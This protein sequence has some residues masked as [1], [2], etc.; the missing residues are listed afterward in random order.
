MNPEDQLVKERLR[1][2][3]EIQEAGK[4]PYSY[5]YDQKHKAADLQE[6]FKKLKKEAKAKTSVSVAGRL[7]ILRRMGKVTFA[8][9]QDGT[10][11]IQLYFKQDDIGNKN[12]KFLKKL[13]I[14]DI[15][16]VKGIIFRTKMGELTVYVKKYDL[17][18]KSLRPLPEKYHGLKDVEARYRQRYLDLIMNPDVKQTFITR[19]KIYNAMREF[20]TKE[21]F[22]EVETPTLQPIYGGANARPFITK[23]NTLDMDLYLRISNELYLKRLIVGGFE[24]VFEFCKDFRNEGIDTKHNPEFSMMETM[25]A[26]DDYEDSMKRVERMLEF[27]VK[28]VTGS[29]KITYQENIINLKAPFKKITMVE[30]VKKETGYD[31][32]KIKNLGEARKIAK[33]LKINITPEMGVGAIL[34]E[35][36]DEKCESEREKKELFYQNKI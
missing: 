19:T 16:G 30:A 11:R 35:I 36:C 4:N 6:N 21:G 9:L 7:K 28:K 32:E 15:I 23:H 2:L 29:T 5:K 26:Y 22:L 20:L 25:A 10:G 17:L 14:G 12:Y 8:D 24:K 34:A 33:Q 27:I 31:F 3:K 13:D 1:K 18:T